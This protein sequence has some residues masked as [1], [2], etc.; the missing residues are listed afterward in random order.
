MAI[1]EPGPERVYVMRIGGPADITLELSN[2][3]TDLD[4]FLLS[5]CNENSCLAAGNNAI[6]YS[7][8]AGTYY[9][10]VDGRS[11]TGGSYSLS[12]CVELPAPDLMQPHDTDVICSVTAD[13][14]VLFSW[15]AVYEAVNYTLQYDTEPSLSS[16]VEVTTA[17]HFC[18]ANFPT[19]GNYFWRVRAN[20]ASGCDN[21]QLYG[22]LVAAGN[23]GL[24]R[25][26]GWRYGLYGLADSV[27]L[28]CRGAGRAL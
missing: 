27:R 1:S 20:N 11:V 15:A 9:I 18:S 28:G 8:A 22:H 16:P 14:T 3:S 13:S 26:G 24:K 23:S 19:N 2:L 10:V 6:T 21:G 7:A 25:A 5:A 12:Y 17:T 4:L